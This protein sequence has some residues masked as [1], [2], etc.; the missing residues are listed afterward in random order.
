MVLIAEPEAGDS[1]TLLS[2]PQ[3]QLLDAMLV[4]C[5]IA[6]ER[7]YVASLLPRHTPMSDWAALGAAGL[8]EIALHHIALATPQRMWVFGHN[9]LPLVGHDPAKSPADLHNINHDGGSVTVLA[10]GDLAALLSR[11][12][13][14]AAWWARW[15]DWTGT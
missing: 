11:P 7:V 9:I 13:T 4:A 12:K 3:G 1:E 14:R 6:R 5:G 15:L 8:G 10:A 2:G